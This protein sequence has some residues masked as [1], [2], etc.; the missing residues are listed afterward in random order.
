MS[1]KVMPIE[2]T[3]KVVG[4]ANPEKVKLYDKVADFIA[5]AFEEEVYHVKP[6]TIKDPVTKKNKKTGSYGLLFK[7]PGGSLA[8]L[9]IVIKSDGTSLED[10]TVEATTIPDII[11]EVEEAEKVEE[12][13]EVKTT[14]AESKTVIESNNTIVKSENVT[15]QTNNAVVNFNDDDEDS[16]YYYNND[17]DNDNDNDDEIE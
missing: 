8:T 2:S 10:F 17:N 7:L 16:D 12:V 14:D 4:I 13:E 1:K 9:E 6:R 3:K 5:K 15:V 11:E